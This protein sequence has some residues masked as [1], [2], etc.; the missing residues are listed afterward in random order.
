MPLQG[1]PIIDYYFSGLGKKDIGNFIKYICNAYK[2][3]SLPKACQ[4]LTTDVIPERELDQ[5]LEVCFVND[6]ASPITKLGPKDLHG[7]TKMKFWFLPYRTVILQQ[8]KIGS[9]K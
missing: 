8:G 3:T 9:C 6:D 4:E 7:G 5:T 2:G 1:K